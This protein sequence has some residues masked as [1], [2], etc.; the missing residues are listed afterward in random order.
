MHVKTWVLDNAVALSGSVNATTIGMGENKE[1]MFRITTPS[2]V[3]ELADDFED[4]WGKSQP[5]SDEHLDSQI[6][7]HRK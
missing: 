2:V 6:A 1:H 5:L 3:K 7:A 4:L